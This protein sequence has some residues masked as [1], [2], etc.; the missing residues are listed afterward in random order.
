MENCV[1]CK[2]VAGELPSYC[3]YEDE[4]F[5]VILDINPATIGHTLILTKAHYENVY[6]LGEKEGGVLM[7]LASKISKKLKEALN[8]DGLNILQNNGAQAGQVV[9]HYHMH[10]IPRYKNDGAIIKWTVEKPTDVD[11]RNIMD[12]LKV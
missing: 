11:F 3:I 6:E 7:P 12:K 8:C 2:I 10:L 1:F 5:K 9:N 4:L